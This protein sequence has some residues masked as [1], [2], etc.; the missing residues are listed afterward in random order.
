[1]VGVPVMAPVVALMASP[2]GRPEAAHELIVAPDWVVV[3][4]FGCDVMAEPD[5]LDL[6]ATAV[7]ATVLLMVHENDADPLKPEPSVAVRVTV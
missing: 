4:E 6:L 7:M 5:T 3:A 1:M 2:A